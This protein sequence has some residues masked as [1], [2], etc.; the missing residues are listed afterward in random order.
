VLEV[1]RIERL[2]VSVVAAATRLEAEGATDSLH[3]HADH[4]GAFALPPEGRHREPG[5]VAHR[6]V[7]ALDDRAADRLAKL[8]EVDAVAGRF[9]ALV[10][11]PACERLGLRGAE[12]VAVEEQLEDPPVLLRLR[13]RR[14]EGLAEVALIGPADLLERGEGIENLG[15]AHGNTLRAEVL[16]EGEQASR[17]CGHR[18]APRA[19][20][21]RARRRG[22]CRSG[23]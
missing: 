17:G 19:S 22:R 15:G 9:E 2:L 14:G 7:V 16:E 4:P 3:V 18:L 23:A 21:R 8:V 5:E 1:L 13:D 10:L 12:E 20:P 6:T 11:D